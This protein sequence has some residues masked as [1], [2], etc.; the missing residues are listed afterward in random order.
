VPV[1]LVSND[2]NANDRFNWQDITGVQY[3]YPNQYK[4]I[5]QPGERFIYYRGIRRANGGL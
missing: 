2:A 5:I 3:H 1:V 4:N